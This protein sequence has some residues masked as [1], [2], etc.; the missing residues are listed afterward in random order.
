M[1]KLSAICIEND[2]T[3]FGLLK[4]VQSYPVLW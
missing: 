2:G 3:Q 1:F 4:E